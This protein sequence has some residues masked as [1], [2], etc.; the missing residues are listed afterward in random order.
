[1]TDDDTTLESRPDPGWW[2]IKVSYLPRRERRL[3]DRLAALPP[4][5]RNTWRWSTPWSSRSSTPHRPPSA[6]TPGWDA[7]EMVP[8]DVLRGRELFVAGR[9]REAGVPC[10]FVPAGGYQSRLFP[11]EQLADLRTATVEAFLDH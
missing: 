4:G 3:I 6:T 9:L 2:R 5:R 1:M 10:V 11:H 8:E 7:V